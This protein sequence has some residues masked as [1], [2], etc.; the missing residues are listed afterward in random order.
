VYLHELQEER[1]STVEAVEDILQISQALTT[2]H[3]DPYAAVG[4][5]LAFHRRVADIIDTIPNDSV[6]R[7][8]LLAYLRPLVAALHDGHTAVRLTGTAIPAPATLKQSGLPFDWDIVSEHIYIAGVYDEVHSGLL[9]ARLAAV[10]SVPFA[11]L[12]RRMGVQ[13]G[14]DNVV[15]NLTHLMDA[16]GDGGQLA[17]L[18]GVAELANDR[19]AEFGESEIPL[20]VVSAGGQSHRI[21]CRLGASGPALCPESALSLPALN[22]SDLAGGFIGAGERVAY[23]R[24]GALMRYREAFEIWH[25]TGFERLLGYHLTDVATAAHFGSRGRSA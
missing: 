3:P 16:L 24:I 18:V 8:Q 5:P 11:E 25:T 22:A 1:M 10:G 13:R 23:L 4:G 14:F 19:P 7:L 20:D 15:N 2:A 12:T 6:T 9:G 21:L 17:D